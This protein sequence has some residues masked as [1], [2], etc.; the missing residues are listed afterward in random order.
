M[1]NEEAKRLLDAVNE[2]TE[3]IKLYQAIIDTLKKI[4]MKDL[5]ELEKYWAEKYKNK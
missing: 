3:K 2:R 1:T 4:N 5:R